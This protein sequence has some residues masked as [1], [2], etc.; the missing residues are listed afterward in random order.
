MEKEYVIQHKLKQARDF[1]SQ[2]KFLHSIQI[3]HSLI[4]EFPD[5]L[6]AY[7]SLAALYEH[8]DN[9]KSA[10]EIF[11]QIISISPDDNEM[12]IYFA[13]FLFRKMDW[14][15]VINIL[16]KVD[17]ENEPLVSFLVGTSYLFLGKHELAKINLLNF[18]TSDEQ[19]ELI[20]GAYLFLAKIDLY[21][22]QYEN[23]LKYIR[24]AETFLDD[25]WE[26][27]LIYARIYF[28]QEM[29]THSLEYLQKAIN[30]NSNNLIVN[31]WAGKLFL[32]MN[33]NKKAQLYINKYLDLTEENSSE[34]YI[35]KARKF[36]KS[37][38]IKEALINF[39]M[40]DYYIDKKNFVSN[41]KDDTINPSKKLDGTDD[42]Y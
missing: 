1:E 30:G 42:Q 5:F 22:K 15:G 14:S 32:K 10:N 41:L 8:I 18:I 7:L 36:L 17:P 12:R 2:G 3:Y 34:D 40:A 37:G 38:K 13:Q 9:P 16:I 25:Y 11:E 20:Y 6:H 19:P 23:A 35:D 4:N 39:E 28:E 27:Y 31:Y 24:R 33:N 29:Y 26:L 21:L